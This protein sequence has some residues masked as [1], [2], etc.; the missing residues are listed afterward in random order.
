[1][2]A[3]FDPRENGNA[4][5]AWRPLLASLPRRDL[6]PAGTQLVVLAAH[7]DDETLGCGALLARAADAG[8]AV[9]VIVATDGEASHPHSSTHTPAMLAGLRRRETAQAI[10]ILAPLARLTRLGLPDG[11]LDDADAALRS[12]LASAVAPGP[13][14]L[15]TTWEGDR[16]PDHA[17][18]ARAARH[19]AAGRANC[20]VLEFPIWAWHWADPA[21]TRQ[22]IGSMARIDA[23]AAAAARRERALDV[24]RSQ[25]RPLSPLPGDEAILGPDVIAH[26][27]RDYDVVI[28]PGRGDATRRGPGAAADPRYFDALYARSDDPWGIGSRWYEQRKRALVLASLPRQHF[29]RCFE[30]GCAAGHLTTE[31][32]ARCARVVA[33][34]AAARA[35]A[36]TRAATADRPGV[37]VRQLRIPRQWPAGSFDL[38][39]LSEIGYYIDDL[40]AL[41]DRVGTCMTRDGTLALCHWR[42][43]ATEHVRTAESVHHFLRKRTGLRLIASHR[44]DDFLLDVLTVDGRS[45]ARSDGIVR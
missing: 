1:M 36:L 45:V 10:R 25:L 41:A 8:Y 40:A 17:A 43:A 24:Y 21:A 35:V 14:W 7:P 20:T 18:C 16:H 22:T 13:T 5:T 2:T 12:A 26:F 15:L 39:V 28:E 33:V 9:T 11:G 4:P 19:A 44:E 31:L 34:D 27:H 32:A 29:A 6:P 38:V 42:H 23:G 3:S 30:A 37:V